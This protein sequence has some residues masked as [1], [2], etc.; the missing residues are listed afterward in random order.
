MAARQQ[1]LDPIRRGTEA[2]LERILEI[3][4]LSFEKQWFA[5]EFRSA[6]KELFLVYQEEVVLGFLSACLTAPGDRAVIMRIAVHP[7]HRGKGIASRLIEATLDRLRQMSVAEVEL[8]V[9]IVKTGAIAL[10]ERFGFRIREIV[11]ADDDKGSESFLEMK[12]KLA[13]G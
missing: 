10:Y 3:E 12:L 4:K 8:E 2:D 1:D 13:G 11:T 5:D 9:E 6:L 7:D